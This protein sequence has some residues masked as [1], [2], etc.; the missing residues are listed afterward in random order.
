MSS[1]LDVDVNK[2]N[3]KV[4]EKLKGMGIVVPKFV[5]V[6]KSGAHA[7]RPPEQD[8]FF[9]VRCASVMRQ[10]YVRN[11]VGVQRLRTHYGGKKSRGV[12]PER[13]MRAGGST[14]RKAMQALE[15]AGLM[16]KVDKGQRK[17]RTL[18]AKGRKLLDNSAKETK[19]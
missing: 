7:D 5:G 3:A 13:Y 10:A 1:A 12:R 8:D 11:I 4:A 14:V 2:L 19:G 6:V 15:K 9:F 16:E 17:G 18:T